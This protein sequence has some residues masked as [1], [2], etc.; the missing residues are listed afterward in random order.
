MDSRKENLRK[1][2][3]DL[4]DTPA[5]SHLFDDRAHKSY[6]LSDGQSSSRFTHFHKCILMT[7]AH[8][9][10]NDYLME[11]IKENP[12]ELNKV[13]KANWSSLHLATRNCNTWSIPKTVK[14][15]LDAGIKRNTKTQ[16]KNYTALHHAVEFTEDEEIVLM[17][18]EAGVKI[19]LKTKDGETPLHLAVKLQNN[20]N[21]ISF[22]IKAGAKVNL[23]NSKGNTPLHEATKHADW[24]T[25]KTLV[26]AGANANK[27]NNDGLTPLHLVADVLNAEPK[28]KYLISLGV[29]INKLT[30][31]G[32]SALHLA[33]SNGQKVSKFAVSKLL[34]NAGIDYNVLNYGGNK[35]SD[36]DAL[37][38][39]YCAFKELRDKLMDQFVEIEEECLI[40]FTVRKT[41]KCKYNHSICCDCFTAISKPSCSYCHEIFVDPQISNVVISD[42]EEIMEE[43]D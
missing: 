14:I 29:K 23:R 10:I 43:V 17:L 7:A 22:L 42:E 36:Y 31:N 28:V 9:T 21:I 34:I 8:P 11:Y 15:L 37:V 39:E 41:M 16:A 35:A 1:Y 4:V 38:V 40:C 27:R 20:K 25:M 26:D 13:T 19:N 33:C 30:Y 18:I 32:N 24:Q 12:E 2:V 6:Q 3:G 5:F